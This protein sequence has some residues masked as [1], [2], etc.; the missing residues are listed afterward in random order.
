MKVGGQRQL[1]VPPELAY[2]KN[3]Y[4]EIPG[5]ATLTID[6]QLL[7]IKQNAL[8]ARVKLVEG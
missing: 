7:S 1:L 2:G 5:N 3:G 6:V 8:G 4:G